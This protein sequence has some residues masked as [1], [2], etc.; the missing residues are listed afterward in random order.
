MPSMISVVLYDLSHLD[1][2]VEQWHEVGSPAVTIID[3]VGTRGEREPGRRSDFPLLPSI[4]DL[5]QAEDAPR[6]IVFSLVPDAIVDSLVRVTEQIVG[7]LLET[8]NGILFVI[9][10]SRVVGMR[11][12]KQANS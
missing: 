5:L 11:P 8:G 12:P 10:V 2:L 6:K 3:C 4:R 1:E 7:D 9:P